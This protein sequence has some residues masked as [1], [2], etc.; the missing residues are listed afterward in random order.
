[1]VNPTVTA[2]FAVVPY[3]PVELDGFL[4]P[5]GEFRQSLNSTARALGVKRIGGD[6]IAAVRQLAL[7][8]ENTDAAS[9]LAE[10]TAKSSS[11]ILEVGTGFS[12]IAGVAQTIDLNTVIAFWGYIANAGGKYAA[13]ATELLQIGAR[14]SLEGVYREAF[15]IHDPRSIQDQLL[16]AWLDLDR[17][18]RRPIFD[19]QFCQSILRV[20]GQ[21]FY[22]KNP[23]MAVVI[24]EL[25]WHRIPESVMAQMKEL[26]PVT[27]PIF[28][29]PDGTEVGYR[30][31]AYTQL[32][33]DDAFRDAV[34]PI[35]TAAKAMCAAAPDYR[36]GGYRWVL[37][38]LD[39]TFPR[40]VKRGKANKE[41]G[42]GQLELVEA[43]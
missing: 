42:N 38:Q 16:D 35:A 17:L 41:V 29:K 31:Y 21:N 22:G 1:M 27:K 32:L 14:V 24:S 18:K 7:E 28:T 34:L 39:K 5:N 2:Q 13:R 9:L 10:N 40:T 19:Q 36:D 4:M 8:Q 15:G 37:R 26:N 25:I 12:G 33:S 43:A 30:R 23:N 20:T 3:G 11:P 6:W